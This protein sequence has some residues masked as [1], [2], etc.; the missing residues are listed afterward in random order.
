MKNLKILI[1]VC[2]LTIGVLTGCKEDFE[3]VT[4]VHPF[5]FEFEIVNK[6]GANLLD[7]N[8]AGNVLDQK[9]TVSYKDRIFDVALQKPENE[10]WEDADSPMAHFYGAYIED[11]EGDGPKIMFGEVDLL[12]NNGGQA[13]VELKIGDKAYQ[14]FAKYIDVKRFV[15]IYLNGKEIK[16]DKFV[17]EY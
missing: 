7:K 10:M 13:E 1:T 2:I 16:D 9:M 11:V 3:Y 4:P 15:L 5:T 8:V 6:D 14:A 12:W 17:L